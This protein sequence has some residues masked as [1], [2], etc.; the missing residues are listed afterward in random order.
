VSVPTLRLDVLPFVTPGDDTANRE[1]IGLLTL[2]AHGC[3]ELHV[4]YDF[5]ELGSREL[6]F[7]RAASVQ[8]RECPP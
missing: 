7:E 4:E 1:E 8:G 3:N 5:A 2:H 6:N